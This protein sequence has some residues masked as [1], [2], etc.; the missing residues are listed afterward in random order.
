VRFEVLR[1]D[2]PVNLRSVHESMVCD[3]ES[4]R[5]SRLWQLENFAPYLKRGVQQEKVWHYLSLVGPVKLVMEII[6]RLRV[7]SRQAAMLPFS[8]AI[9]HYLGDQ[10]SGCIA[11]YV[12]NLTS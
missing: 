4:C 2:L 5:D 9:V 8:S 12:P 1:R 6:Q 3:V 11:Y 7:W 10:W